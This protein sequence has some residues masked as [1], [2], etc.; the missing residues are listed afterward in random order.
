[1]AAEALNWIWTQRDERGFWDLGSQIARRPYTPFPLSESWRRPENRIIDC[2][3]EMLTLLSK[4]RGR[5][6]NG[7]SGGRLSGGLYRR[8]PGSA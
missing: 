2:T 6:E 8:F 5:P 3:V 4:G 7:L 1:M